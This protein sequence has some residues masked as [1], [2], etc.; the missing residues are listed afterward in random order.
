[1][2]EKITPMKSWDEKL[3]YVTS[4]LPMLTGDEEYLKT[5]SAS[6]FGRAKSLPVYE[7]NPTKTIRSHTTLLK[8]GA[9]ILKAEE[10]YGLSKVSISYALL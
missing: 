7:W 5:V 1:L 2:V 8:A 3:E 4:I 9:A 6:I 10:D